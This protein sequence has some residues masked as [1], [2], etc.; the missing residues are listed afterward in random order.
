M[1][2]NKE[3]HNSKTIDFLKKLNI[4]TSILNHKSSHCSHAGSCI[5]NIVS[6]T[7]KC[8]KY[9]YLIRLVFSLIGGLMVIKSKKKGFFSNFS[10]IFSFTISFS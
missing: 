9:G 6:S 1:E 10:Y 5:E 8:F 2:E 4:P 3:G 7:I